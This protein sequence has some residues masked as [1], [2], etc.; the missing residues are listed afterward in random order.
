MTGRMIKYNAKG[1]LEMNKVFVKKDFVFFWGNKASNT[2]RISKACLSQWWSCVFYE[3]GIRYS[4]TE[5]YMMYQKALIF[6]D[7]IMAE[8]IILTTNPKEIKGYGRKISGFD[9]EYWRKE[10]ERIVL[11]GNMLKFTQNTNL[12]DYLLSTKGKI[13]VEAS[14]FDRIW[15][16]RMGENDENICNLNEWKGENLLGFILMEVRDRIQ[17]TIIDGCSSNM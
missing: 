11:Q 12:Y 1:L 5:Q 14:P 17:Q 2:S 10:R 6:K 7:H 13:L 15:G 16:I 3:N 8:R 9:E 4:S